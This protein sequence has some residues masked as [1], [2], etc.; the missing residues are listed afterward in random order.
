MT[1]RN[2]HNILR[3][4][5]YSGKIVSTII[6]GE[7]IQGKH[8]PLV[9][10]ELFLTANG[11]KKKTNKGYKWN[12]ADDKLPMRAFVRCEYCGTGYAGYL[13]KAKGL[14]HNKC[15]KK[16]CKCNKRAETM[17]EQFITY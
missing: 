15:N 6:A 13:V 2:V 9:S 12:S 11:L 5:F 3:N 16:G 4:P 17:H 14:Y 8:E 10:Q 1:K 7:I